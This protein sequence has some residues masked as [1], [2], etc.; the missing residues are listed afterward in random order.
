MNTTDKIALKKA[1]IKFTRA[2]AA[3][4]EDPT[5]RREAAYQKAKKELAVLRISL[6]GHTPHSKAGDAV[7]TPTSLSV[8]AKDPRKGS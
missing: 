1:K 2:K 4:V 3:V 8:K 7:A 5:S 6:R